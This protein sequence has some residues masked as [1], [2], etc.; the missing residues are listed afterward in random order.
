MKA[1]K[2]AGLN[3]VQLWVVWGWVEPKPDTFEYEEY[4][5]LVE[6]A[7]KHDLQLVLST[8]AAVQP[9][10][11]HEEV[12]ESEMI[13]NE[14]TKVI[15][16]HRRECH[17]GITPGGCIDNPGVWDRIALFLKTTAERYK[18]S[19]SLVGWDVWNE[20]RWN[21]QSDGLVCYCPHTLKRFRAWLDE[22]YGGLD[23]L[24]RAW[25]RKYR[26]W[27][28]VMPGKVPGRPYTEMMAFQDFITWRSNDFAVK[29]YD[30][31][32]EIDP[33]R[34]VTVHGAKPTPLHGVDSYYNSSEPST[35]LHRGN[36]WVFSEKIDGIGCSS[37]PIWENIDDYDFL[38]RIEFI[39]SASNGKD[40]WLS[41]LQGGRSATAFIQ[42]KPVPAANQQRWV[43]GGIGTGAKTVLFWCWRDE[44]FGRESGGFGISGADG[45]ADERV[46][47]L[48]KTGALLRQHEQLLDGYK[49]DDA[50]V[51]IWFSPLSY[52]HHWS[53]MGDAVTPMESLM[54]Y[55]RVCLKRNIPYQVVEERHLAELDKLSI[56]FMPRVL[57]LTEEAEQAL[58]R[59]VRG[60]GILVV[61]S[62]S[63]AFGENGI[64]KYPNERF[65]NKVGGINEAGRRTLQSTTVRISVAGRTFTVGAGQWTTRF[66]TDGGG[67]QLVIDKKVGKG[68][69]IG[70]GTYFGQAY[71]QL[72]LKNPTGKEGDVREEG[73][74]GIEGQG[75]ASE[76]E[77]MLLTFC[78]EAGVQP[79]IDIEYSGNNTNR[80]T[81]VRTG[82]SN[83]KRMIFAY[84]EDYSESTTLR[85]VGRALPDHYT[86]IINGREYSAE[87]RQSIGG[88]T[89]SEESNVRYLRLEP[90]DWGVYVLVEK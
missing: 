25:H 26:T 8:I 47:A 31:V 43:W 7:E 5:K 66:V 41:E 81:H 35:T 53:E 52:Y 2:E 76:F 12:P 17:F 74:V 15:S 70:L 73:I 21:V 16:S 51:G 46:E 38:S 83:G 85:F 19:K 34:P 36:D 80:F 77:N 87:R 37:F 65:L 88:P 4:D 45:K 79:S 11:I 67:E 48:R 30:V 49:K 44:V 22:K 3:T 86:D 55:T 71:Y 24:N 9:Y 14:G 61:E 40:I 75:L 68:R 39:R 82:S 64:Y 6:T 13:T 18:S 28:H 42:Q 27:D 78:E 90:S 59:F 58:E 84:T 23:G 57:V 60:G 89:A 10:W 1:M 54:G 72:S 32:K 29:R 63:G 62:E 50:E 69:I 33:N 56:L 20:L